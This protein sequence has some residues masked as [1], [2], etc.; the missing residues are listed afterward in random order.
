MALNREVRFGNLNPSTEKKV[1]ISN[2]P[3]SY[4]QQ[5]ISWQFGLMDFD[6]D[7]G[8]NHVIDRIEFSHAVKE[9]MQMYLAQN[10]SEE[11]YN[12]IDKLNTS[13]FVNLT[14]FFNKI[15]T[16]QSIKFEELLYILSS[17]KKNFFWN[18]LYPKLKDFE[19]KKWWELENEKFGKSGKSKH[20]WVSVKKIIKPAQLRLLKLNIDDIDEIFSIRLTGTQRVWGIRDYN[21][22]KILWFDFN[23]EICP[24]NKD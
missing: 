4:K 13:D 23:H 11:L 7:Y 17:F 3:E 6:F 18:E 22:F 12:A 15:K 8:W 14:S 5:N 2:N 1:K 20:H 10:N 9:E 21:Y 24:S 16:I 19:S